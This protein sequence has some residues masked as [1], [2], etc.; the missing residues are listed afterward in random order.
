MSQ[1]V[2]IDYLEQWVAEHAAALQAEGLAIEFGRGNET[3]SKSMAFF[4]LETSEWIGELLIWS[5]GEVE[6]GA[7]KRSDGEE[8][9]EHH[10]VASRVD[11]DSLLGR[12]TNLVK[13][14]QG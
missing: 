5:S 13:P 12:L 4:N 11:L 2:L 1:V 10:Q 6:L 9:N 14:G 3:R 7:T 8:V